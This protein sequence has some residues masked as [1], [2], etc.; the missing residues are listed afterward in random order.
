M[1]NVVLTSA[2]QI[3]PSG[4]CP[5]NADVVTPMVPVEQTASA[6]VQEESTIDKNVVDGNVQAHLDFNYQ[7]HDVA[8]AAAQKTNGHVEG[9]NG[10]KVPSTEHQMEMDD[11]FEHPDKGKSCCSLLNK[12]FLALAIVC[13][14]LFLCSIAFIVANLDGFNGKIIERNLVGLSS[15]PYQCFEPFNINNQLLDDPFFN[16]THPYRDGLIIVLARRGA[17]IHD[18]LVPEKTENG[19]IR[20]RSIVLR[21]NAENHFGSIR[22]G[23]DDEMTSNN[24][25]SQL[26]TDY[27]FLNA[28]KENWSLF[29]DRTRPYRA[30]FVNGL[31]EV[32]YEIS[33][34]DNNELVMTTIVSA[35]PNQQ[36]IVDPTNNIFFNLRGHGDL[37]THRFN[38][39]SAVPIDLKTNEKFDLNQIISDRPIDQLK[40]LSNYFY[41]FDRAGLGKNFVGTLSESEKGMNLHLFSDHAGLLIDPTGFIRSDPQGNVSETRGI[42]LSP[43]QTPS[44][45][46][47][48]I[49]GPAFVVY[50]SQMIH[51]TWWQF[52]F[53]S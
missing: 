52:E 13:F 35:P 28:F 22:F 12:L 39:T 15:Y 9:S 37:S 43:R 48:S 19:Q 45:Q 33:R 3:S 17:S 46:A 41:K 10:L 1:D 26:P 32:I 11:D 53:N 4:G 38:F 30:R 2:T 8:L 34:S 14:A 36:I 50:P 49:F 27:P 31:A 20:Y 24:L 21:G 29:A 16:I 7:P 47:R 51:S 5:L 18:I 42:R 25:T 23:F 6:P 40:N 44:F